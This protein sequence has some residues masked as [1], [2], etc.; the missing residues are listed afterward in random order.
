[1]TKNVFL[2]WKLKWLDL[3]IRKLSLQCWHDPK[4]L[5]KIN[6]L[7]EKYDSLRRYLGG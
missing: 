3:Q 2:H 6:E 5:Y 7:E 4:L 1:M